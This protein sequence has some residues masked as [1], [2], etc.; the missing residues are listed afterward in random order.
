MKNNQSIIVGVLAGIAAGLMVLAAFKAGVL[1]IVLFFAA[2]AAVYIASMG[3]GSL[4]G[5]IAAVTGASLAAGAGD[6]SIAGL[7]LVLLF[8][9]AAYVGHLVNLGQRDENGNIIWFPLSDILLRLMAILAIG[10]VL[11][12]ALSGYT[13]ELAAAAIVEL[14]KQIA[15]T[16]PE[17]PQLNDELL[18]DRA[19]LYA[20]IIPAMLPCMWLLLHVV[21]AFISAN[22]TRRSGLLARAPEDV[23]ASVSLP[24]QASVF[25]AVGLAGM[26]LFTGA[27]KLVGGVSLG[28]GIA[29]YAL[30][31]LAAMHFRTRP[32]QSRGLLLA[33]AYGSIILFSLP[34][35]VFTFIGLLRSLQTNQ[36]NSG[37]NNGSGN[38]N[39]SNQNEE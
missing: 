30:I 24:F 14:M 20:G 10:F 12:G 1:A 38:S 19:N 17:L 21:T 23:A 33:I 9:P 6:N 34:L 36:P 15:S 2:P 31:G 16:N 7:A 35:L 28:I 32:L 25:L 29:G 37:S 39:S 18:L 26:F 13:Q 4:A 11:I 22:I 5:I 8:A 27:L 3:W